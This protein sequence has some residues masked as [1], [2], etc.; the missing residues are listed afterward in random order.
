MFDW[1]PLLV[2]VQEATF[3]IIKL[4]F[5]SASPLQHGQLLHYA[6]R[7]NLSDCLEVLDFAVLATDPPINLVVYQNH[8][9][10]YYRT[11]ASGT[12]THLHN[13][14]SMGKLDVAK[15]ARGQRSRFL[16]LEYAR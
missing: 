10:T 12:G 16:S 6:V 14:A 7:R 4:L 11:Q 1:T 13:A 3:E 2:A 15:G 9:G 5:N 8:L